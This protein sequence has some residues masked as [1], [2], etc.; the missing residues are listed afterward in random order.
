[1]RARLRVTCVVL[2]VFARRVL[3]DRH[4][5]SG[6]VGRTADVGLRFVAGVWIQAGVVRGTVGCRNGLVSR[7]RIAFAARGGAGRRVLSGHGAYPRCDVNERGAISPPEDETAPR[8]DESTAFIRPTAHDSFVR[9]DIRVA[10]YRLKTRRARSMLAVFMVA[11]ACARFRRQASLM[12]W[13]NESR[14]HRRLRVVCA[15]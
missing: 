8:T 11:A 15:P 4:T 2:S 14:P 6:H 3:V 7:V 9:R 1:M 12:R 10:R 5:A 13:Y